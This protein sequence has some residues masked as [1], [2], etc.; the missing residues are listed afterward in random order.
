MLYSDSFVQQDEGLCI[1]SETK[2]KIINLHSPT[3]G[4]TSVE[5]EEQACSWNPLE[6]E[7]DPG[8]TSNSESAINSMLSPRITR[9]GQILE[10]SG[11]KYHKKVF[12]VLWHSTLDNT[13]VKEKKLLPCASYLPLI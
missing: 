13:P 2:R 6:A 1:Q 5:H 12:L 9:N 8:Y 11:T 4:I 10:R 7:H 3:S